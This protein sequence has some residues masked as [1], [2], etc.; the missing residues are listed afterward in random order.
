M[1]YYN[2]FIIGHATGVKWS[3]HDSQQYRKQLQRLYHWYHGVSSPELVISEFEENNTE[4]PHFG[5]QAARDRI[6]VNVDGKISSCSKVLALDNMS[7]I[8]PL[9]D[10][11]FDLVHLSNRL[12]MIACTKLRTA[13]EHIGILHDYKGGCF[14]VNFEETGDLF[15]PSIQEHTF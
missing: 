4:P 2:Q 9:G 10:V 3:R 8:H 7:L 13:C 14:A 5:C 6:S 15:H 12:E 1:T 11:E